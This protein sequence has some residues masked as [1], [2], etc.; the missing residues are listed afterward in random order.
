MSDHNI[1]RNMDRN[2]KLLSAARMSEYESWVTKTEAEAFRSQTR[3]MN[4]FT[5]GY[6][7]VIQPPA[8]QVPVPTAS[9]QLEVYG[10]LVCKLDEDLLAEAREARLAAEAAGE[11]PA[12]V[13]WNR[14][15]EIFQ[16]DLRHNRIQ[17]IEEFNSFKL[18]PDEPISVY[19]NRVNNVRS[20]LRSVGEIYSDEAT[21]MKLLEG[22]KHHEGY[23]LTCQ[24]ILNSL[25]T[26]T[27]PTL[28]VIATQ[29][30]GKARELAA[31]LKQEAADNG[32]SNSVGGFGFVPP[33][34]GGPSNNQYGGRGDEE[35]DRYHGDRG[36]NGRGR[37]GRGRS[38]GRANGG[39]GQHDHGVGRGSG[40]QNR[41]S[42]PKCYACKGFGHLARDC[43]NNNGGSGGG[44][45]SLAA[46]VGESIYGHDTYYLDSCSG[47]MGTPKREAL[48]DFIPASELPAEEL[49]SRVMETANGSR[50]QPAGKGNL[51]L[52]VQG[53]P[54]EVREVYWYPDLKHNLL[55]MKKVLQRNGMFFIIDGTLGTLYRGDQNQ[56][57]K[58]TKVL[59]APW[60]NN[61]LQI[62]AETLPGNLSMWQP[63]SALM[64]KPVESAEPVEDAAMALAAAIYSKSQLKPDQKIS[65]AWE[66]H[67]SLGHSTGHQT[68]AEAVQKG[69]I[70]GVNPQL[71]EV[72]K[73][74][75]PC[76]A[77]IRAKQHREPF[78]DSTRQWKPGEAISV[79]M[80]G[81]ARVESRNHHSWVLQVKDLGSKFLFSV[82][83]RG[84][85]GATSE[86]IRI[87]KRLEREL[88]LKVKLVRFDKGGE[89][90]ND[91][92]EGFCNR[93]GIKRETTTAHTSQ[94]NGSIEKTNRDQLEMTRAQLIRSDM[95]P[96]LWEDALMVSTYQKNRSPHAGNPDSKSP[97]EMM[98][99]RPPDVSH[100]HPF[101]AI[102][103]ALIL[104]RHK[105]GAGKLSPVS[106]KGRMI[107]YSATSKA[108]RILLDSGGV[109]ECRDVQFPGETVRIGNQIVTSGGGPDV[110]PVR[111]QTEPPPTPTASDQPAT[112]SDVEEEVDSGGT[113]VQPSDQGSGLTAQA[114]PAALRRSERLR[115][116]PTHFP[117]EG[118]AAINVERVKDP[119]TLAEMQNSPE[120]AEWNE[121]VQAEYQSLVS[122]G[123]LQPVGYVPV[124]KK[125][126]PTKMVLKQQYDE[127]GQPKKKKGRIV[128]LGFFQI[129]GE[130]YT[131]V[132]AP[133]G[134]LG[135][136]RLALALAA[137]YGWDM[138]QMDF[139]SAF[140][141]AELEEEVYVTLPAGWI[142]EVADGQVFKLNKALYGLKQSPRAW[143]EKLRTGMERIEVIASDSDT[144]LFILRRGKRGKD[145]VLLLCHVDDLYIFGTGGV[146]GAVASQISKR[147]NTE[148]R[149]GN[150]F[151]GMEIA[152]N[153]EFGTIT[154][155][156]RKYTAE[157]LHRFGLTDCKPIT[158]P[159]EERLKLN[160][161][162]GEL[163]DDE[164]IARY[165]EMVGCMMYLAACT[166][167]DIAQS[168]YA[169]GR[170]MSAPSS[171][172][173]K[174]AEHL[175]RYIAGTRDMGI[176]FGAGQ[177]GMVTYSDSDW[178][179]DIETR[180][181]TTGYVVLVDGAAVVWN[182]KLQP[183][184]ATSTVEA[185]YMA[186]ASAA[187]ELIWLRNILS[188][189]GMKPEGPLLIKGDNQGA[190][191][192]AHNPMVTVRTKH[193]D[194][195]H[196]FIRDR[197]RRKEIEFSYVPTAMQVADVLTKAVGAAKVQSCR[198]MMGLVEVE[199]G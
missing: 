154:L 104:P 8:G 88:N 182:S 65:A 122:N 176:R 120:Y 164:G 184:V 57:T 197:V 55:C 44:K 196:H 48:R 80:W 158:T 4:G 117:V 139:K 5:H 118:F 132:S 24:L 178:A 54:V 108:Y 174:A 143:Y 145:I 172:H 32:L 138:H 1:D 112:I 110:N 64:T 43:A 113:D 36:R 20:K 114:T 37:G 18:G 142:P 134:R 129:E 7:E 53:L 56:M 90:L 173:M 181:S 42:R 10:F 160:K 72:I 17:L 149:P 70:A 192:T 119:T 50:M 151:L 2:G 135:S 157:I 93:F 6:W 92:M 85:A 15:R 81:P 83:M 60:H 52:L 79:D 162:D 168:T 150:F 31:K 84:K 13:L 40:D 183:T 39:R 127:S 195:Q 141:Q 179:G 91:E 167:P 30:E 109:V 169:L 148:D 103:Y 130:D 189:I 125:V 29:L 71:A 144:A 140:L 126:I 3:Q 21:A 28:K 147:F 47:E 156:Q 136:F 133:V 152:R 82:P 38:G 198:E 191:S 165:R 97:W 193:I 35:R 106:Q 101:G 27:A 87:I 124:G 163:L 26:P 62:Q 11:N 98:H 177:R 105:R 77:C 59:E 137:R 58:A 19:I 86:V 16:G 121:A 155:S 76:D 194:V 45:V 161:T 89:F 111:D 146:V 188:D 102:A 116:S 12:T 128:A 22:L 123:V 73:K 166:R 68:L 100:M 63:K 153:L 41:P 190:I 66:L 25:K 75:D 78:S 131:D 69:T 94:Q 49:A 14:L 107:G 46:T 9:A 187:R 96:R 67:D 180:R 74:L 95:P 33:R 175:M 99:G 199:K 185:E 23:T 51:D 34:G 115:Q 61:T 159:A 171:V 170:Y 186:S